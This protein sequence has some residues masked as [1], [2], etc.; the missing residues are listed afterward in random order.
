MIWKLAAIV[1][2]PNKF[3]SPP[4]RQL[5]RGNVLLLLNLRFLEHAWSFLT[6]VN[7]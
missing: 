7:Q 5:Y 4:T 2:Y 1:K 6:E 3:T